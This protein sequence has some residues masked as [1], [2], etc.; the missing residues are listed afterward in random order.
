[1]SREQVEAA[2]ER[3]VGDLEQLPPMVSAVKVGG[4]RLHQLARAGIDVERAP[5]RVRV[6]RLVVESFEPGPYPAAIVLVECGSGTYVRSL[7][8][9]L[10][11]ALGG[12]AHLASLR[13]L[14]VGSFTLAE[15]LTLPA[16]EADPAAAVLPLATAM[17]DLE[18]VDVDA[19]QA[20]AASHGIAFPVG[21]LGERGAGPFAVVGPAGD[22][23]AVYERSAAACK[24]AV[25]LVGTDR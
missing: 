8:A 2:T 21:A 4:R 24:P 11:V 25:V 3:F 19:E 13:R 17:R 18:R 12:C 22:L 1:V 5:R 14:A 10:G 16:V 7:A 9:D 23:V 15:A 6:H 20:R